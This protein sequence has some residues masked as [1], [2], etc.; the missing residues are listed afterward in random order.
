MFKCFTSIKLKAT[1]LGKLA[2]F[3]YSQNV[4]QKMQLEE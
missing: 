2:T 1:L 3:N 4:E